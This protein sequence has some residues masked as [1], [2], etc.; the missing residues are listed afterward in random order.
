MTK[1][2]VMVEIT[3]YGPSGVTYFNKADDPSTHR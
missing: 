2:P 1:E 3:G